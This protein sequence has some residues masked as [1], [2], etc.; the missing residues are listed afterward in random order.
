MT[1]LPWVVSIAG[2]QM[3]LIGGYRI[4]RALRSS[5]PPAL[6]TA[7]TTSWPPSGWRG[8]LWGA[9]YVVGGAGS[10]LAVWR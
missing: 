4:V 8:A 7:A 6:E 10:V 1:L 3:S 5:N 9:L 2:V